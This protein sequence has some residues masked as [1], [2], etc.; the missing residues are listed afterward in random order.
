MNRFCAA[1]AIIVLAGCSSHTGQQSSTNTPSRET[2]APPA[3]RSGL[4]IDPVCGMEVRPQASPR[5]QYNGQT[6]YFCS[7]GCE[8]EFKK[9]PAAYLRPARSDAE[10]KV[11]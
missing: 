10:N 4:E 5:E 7:E 8:E 6:I 11:R 2:Q 1:L 3:S 9:S